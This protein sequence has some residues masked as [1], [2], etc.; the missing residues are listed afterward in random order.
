MIAIIKYNAGNSRSVQNALKR[1]GYQSTIT[2]NLKQIE[3]ADHVIFPGVGQAAA[4]MNFLE[5]SGI[6]ELILN[7]TQ[8][9][10]GICLGLQ[11]MCRYSDESDTQCLGIFE[12]DVKR[13]PPQGIVPHT[14][15]NNFTRLE[16]TLFQEL[17]EGNHMYFVHSYYAEV[18]PATT[19]V[20]AYITPFSAAVQKN[21]FYGVQFHPEKSGKAGEK[22]LLNFLS[23]T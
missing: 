1:L 20:C 12:T 19:A 4:A 2:N 5:K 3:K 11:L 21:N 13:F 7:L 16:G 14:G 17:N 15:W 10:L 9:V 22:I 6:D 8:P 18:C 23:R